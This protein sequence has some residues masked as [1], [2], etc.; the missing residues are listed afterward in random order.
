[1]NVVRASIILSVILVV[2]FGGVIAFMY[3]SP[4]DGE[5][6]DTNQTTPSEPPSDERLLS[7]TPPGITEHDNQTL[8]ISE[9]DLMVYHSQEIER[10]SAEIHISNG[11]DTEKIIKDSDE[12]VLVESDNMGPD[13]SSYTDGEYTL[14]RVESSPETER[15]NAETDTIERRDYT[16]EVELETLLRELDVE[17]YSETED[18]HTEIALTLNESSDQIAH[19]YGFDEVGSA[20]VEMTVSQDGIIKSADVELIGDKQ[21]VNEVYHSSFEVKE[22][23]EATLSTPSWVSE[24]EQEVTVVDGEYDSDQGWIIIEH[25]GFATVPHDAGLQL[26]DPET[27]EIYEASLPESFEEGDILGLRLTSDGVEATMNEEPDAG[28]E[29]EA[30]SY[31]ITTGS[32]TDGYFTIEVED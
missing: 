28:I 3:I 31:A 17:T 5:N 23:G 2:V 12:S 25:K 9:E 15:Y 10:E 18:Q 4:S 11:S 1:M 22:F 13:I 29:T 21:G 16:K 8:T 26:L 7:E 24:A 32:S 20:D 27:E 30:D 6:G 14:E 19:T